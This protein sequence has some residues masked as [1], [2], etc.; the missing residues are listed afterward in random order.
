MTLSEFKKYLDPK[1]SNFQARLS[2]RLN[3]LT[4]TLP[5]ETFLSFVTFLKTNSICRFQQLTDLTAVDFPQKKERF[6]MVYHFLSYKIGQRVRVKFQISADMEVPSLVDLYPCACWWE[7]E[8]WDMFGILF[9]GTHDHRRILTDYGFEGHPLR[10]D[11]PVSGHIEAVYDEKQ[12][13]VT[14]VPV[15]LKQ[16]FRE[17][18]FVSPWQGVRDAVAGGRKTQHGANNEKG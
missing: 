11:F 2:E 9:A 16:E 4:V 7:R 1:L 3:E 15:S 10:K 14:H 6:E 17:F 5:C 8:V 12:K 18:D 13:K